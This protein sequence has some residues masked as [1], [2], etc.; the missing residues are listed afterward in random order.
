[1]TLLAWAVAWLLDCLIGDPRS[2]PHP[3]RWIGAMITQS[4]RLVRHFCRSDRAAGGRGD[5]QRPELGRADA[6]A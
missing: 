2:L 6:G 3:V 4:Q 5:N 1:M